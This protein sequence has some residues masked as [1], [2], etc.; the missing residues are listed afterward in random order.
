MPVYSLTVP[1]PT[2]LPRG[3]LFYQGAHVEV[4]YFLTGE[5][6]AY[7]R[8]EATFTRVVP[9][10]DFNIWDGP[11]GLRGEYYKSRRFRPAERVFTQTDPTV[12][13]DFGVF[14]PQPIGA[15]KKN[16]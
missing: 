12:K 5:S 15:G 1:P 7:D 4:L 11:H 8:R 6:R 2:G 10:N 3:T 13:F 9:I 14:E 16:R